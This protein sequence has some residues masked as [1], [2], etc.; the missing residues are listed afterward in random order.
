MTDSLN[1]KETYKTEAFSRDLLIDVRRNVDTYLPIGSYNTPILTVTANDKEEAASCVYE[2]IRVIIV[3]DDEY[4][5]KD[6]ASLG[7]LFQIKVQM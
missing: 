1:I 7:G 3:G 5:M 2:S 6:I 4:Q